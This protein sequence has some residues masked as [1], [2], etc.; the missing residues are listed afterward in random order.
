MQ[1]LT[2]LKKGIMEKLNAQLGEELV[3]EIYLKA[4]KLEKSVSTTASK[5]R[6]RRSLTAAERQKIVESTDSVSDPDLRTAL[7][8]L[9][10]KHLET[11]VS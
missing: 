6:H 9:L 4:G 10:A 1:Q 8:E 3:R 2:F 7:E 5:K 11:L